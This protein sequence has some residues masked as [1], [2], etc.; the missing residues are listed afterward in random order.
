MNCQ[1]ALSLLYDVID[2][3][4]S[5]IDAHQ[6]EEHLARCRDCA[7]VYRV[8]Q[9]VNELLREKLKS[10]QS[11]PRLESLKTKVLSQ[12]NEVDRETRGAEIKGV[13]PSES[14]A[15]PVFKLGKALAIAAAVVIVVGGVILINSIINDHAPYMRLERAHRSALDNPEAYRG[16]VA[17]TLAR[18][19]TQQQLAY[20]VV[21]IIGAFD[22]LGG[23]LETVEDIQ[24]A[25]FV[26]HNDENII[27]VFII[28][29]SLIPI[30]EDLIGTAENRNGLWFFYHNCRGCRLV[31]HRVGEALVVTATTNPEIDLLDFVPNRGPV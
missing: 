5:E 29:P 20:D 15:P 31:Y 9:S 6:V 11:T 12:L 23:Q 25:H 30:P 22:L 28:D 2:K 18:V 26:Y 3:E 17:T 21:E 10:Q 1:E 16:S 8:E 27:S 7:G 24:L 19:E 4:A 14:S 13:I